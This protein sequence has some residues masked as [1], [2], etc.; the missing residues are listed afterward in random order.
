MTSPLRE[1]NELVEVHEVCCHNLPGVLFQGGDPFLL[2]KV[3]LALLVKQ[4]EEVVA[5]I[6]EEGK[7]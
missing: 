6:L 3:P 4:P 5:E 1:I 7:K 2:H